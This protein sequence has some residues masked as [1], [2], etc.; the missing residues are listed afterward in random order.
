MKII[1]RNGKRFL[2]ISKSECIALSKK[3]QIWDKLRN[4]WEGAKGGWNQPTGKPVSQPQPAAPE[5]AA[6]AAAPEPVAPEPPASS[7][8]ESQPVPEAS[9][10]QKA[11]ELLTNLWDDAAGAASAVRNPKEA[12]SN[13]NS[14]LSSISTELAPALNI[15]IPLLREKNIK[16]GIPESQSISE[17][18]MAFESI[19]GSLR[20]QELTSLVKNLRQRSLSTTRP[21]FNDEAKILPSFALSEHTPPATRI[22]LFS[23][24]VNIIITKKQIAQAAIAP[25]TE[26][27][28]E[29]Q[30]QEDE[31]R[32]REDQLFN[33]GSS[34]RVRKTRS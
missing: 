11:T 29:Q 19:A 5:P 15:V 10:E 2:R 12:L 28:K 7:A 16:R 17:A 22:A 31:Q 34:K 20:N 14:L 9:P 18:V 26:L 3:A 13:V 6:P 33:L 30:R 27:A 25:L 32:G 24:I 8:P 23:N 21:G 1:S 4:T